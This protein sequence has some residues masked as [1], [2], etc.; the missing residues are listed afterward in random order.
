MSLLSWWPGLSPHIGRAVNG[1]L[2]TLSDWNLIRADYSCVCW[3]RRAR[4]S[5]PALWSRHPD[6]LRGVGGTGP[7]SSSFRTSGSDRRDSPGCVPRFLPL[8]SGNA[9]VPLILDEL[10]FH[11]GND[12]A[13]LSDAC[14]SAHDLS[15]RRLDS[16]RISRRRRSQTKPITGGQN[17]DDGQIPVPDAKNPRWGEP[18]AL[19]DAA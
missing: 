11:L 3:A 5:P 19:P 8:A 17:H 2:D 4:V 9:D 10:P 1:R 7:P 18:G 6:P 13:L 12:L 15:N 14:A 16:Y